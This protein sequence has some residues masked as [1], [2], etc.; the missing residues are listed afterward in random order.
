M[1]FQSRKRSDDCLS[2][3]LLD[4]LLAG[5]LAAERRAVAQAHADACEP[6]RVRWQA[7]A[8]QAESAALPALNGPRAQ[9]TTTSGSPGQRRSGISRLSWLGLAA[10]A[11]CALLFQRFTLHDDVTPDSEPGERIKGGARL[12][13]FVQRGGAMLRG[14]P[15]EL[16]YPGDTLQLTFFA[17]S[18][19]YIA[20]LGRDATNEVSVYYPSGTRTVRVTAGEQTLPESTLLD[21]T[22]GEETIEAVFCASERDVEALRAALV[23]AAAFAPDGCVLDT[24]RVVKA[25]R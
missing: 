2:D 4:T 12:G 8:R 9:V 17:P 3:M 25:A 22:L 15:G 14:G 10:A 11:C 24:L 16:L 6:C 13:F 1:S 5:D 21:A 7:L 20:V 18:A 19:G 23:R